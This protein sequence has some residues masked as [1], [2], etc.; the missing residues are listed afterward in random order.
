[1]TATAQPEGWNDP[2]VKEVR[3][4]SATNFIA[5]EPF[6]VEAGGE[7]EVVFYGNWADGMEGAEFCA[8]QADYELPKGFAF[9]YEAYDEEE[10]EMVSNVK[11]L[12]SADGGQLKSTH[13]VDMNDKRFVCK[14]SKNAS[15]RG[16]EGKL[17]SVPLKVDASVPDG[18]Y[19]I[20]LTKQIY[21]IV[22]KSSDCVL[23]ITKDPTA[24]GNSRVTEVSRII[25]GDITGISAINTS[26]AAKVTYD[27]Q[28]RRVNNAEKG[29][30]IQNGKKM[31]VK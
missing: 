18:E 31:L 11:I 23:D 20:K 28:G 8:C 15:F 2:M 7:V 25:V 29:V 22:G 24:E 13:E 4:R 16:T 9:V 26:A 6:T 19:T 10:E 27:L 5:V 3:H 1:M 21:A 30:Y 17:F 12:T 14:S